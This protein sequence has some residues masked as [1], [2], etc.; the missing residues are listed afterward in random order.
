[1]DLVLGLRGQDGLLA[2]FKHGS[3]QIGGNCT[4]VLQA[5]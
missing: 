5:E 1:M 3:V 2:L 4:V